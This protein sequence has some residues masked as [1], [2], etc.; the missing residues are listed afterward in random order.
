MTVSIDFK[1]F[2]FSGMTVSIDKLQIKYVSVVWLCALLLQL[3]IGLIF[4]SHLPFY[5]PSALDFL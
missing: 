3:S 4:S 1:V 5:T 2:T